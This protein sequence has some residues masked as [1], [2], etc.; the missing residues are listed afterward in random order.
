MLMTYKIHA[1]HDKSGK[2]KWEGKLLR[3]H[4]I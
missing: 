2:D 3:E 4:W 1:R